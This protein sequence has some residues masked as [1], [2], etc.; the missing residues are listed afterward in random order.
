MPGFYTKKME[1]EEGCDAR[2]RRRRTKGKNTRDRIVSAQHVDLKLALPP[3]APLFPPL[4][5]VRINR[6][7]AHKLYVTGL[8]WIEYTCVAFLY[9]DGLVMEQYP[10][11][12]T[13][14]ERYR[15]RPRRRLCIS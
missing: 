9:P 2:A 15:R 8:L 1:K 5:L 4:H 13:W 6:P 3:S 12:R 11:Y 10:R 7:Q 14:R